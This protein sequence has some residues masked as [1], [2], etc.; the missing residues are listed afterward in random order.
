MSPTVAKREYLCAFC[1]YLFFP[2]E[3]TP[4]RIVCLFQHH[5]CMAYT[6]PLGYFDSINFGTHE[7]LWKFKEPT[8]CA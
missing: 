7:N 8:F 4:F 6:R 2:C 1:S 3:L 5:V